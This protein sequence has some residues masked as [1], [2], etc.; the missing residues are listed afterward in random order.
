MITIY[1]SPSCSS[2]RK[3]KH[4]LD[5]YGLE[6]V[7]KNLFITPLSTQE[8]KDILEKTENGTE[9]IISTRSKVITENNIDIDAMSMNE[10]I[11]FIKENPSALKRPI[12]IEGNKLQI[13]YNAEE[14]RMFIPRE[15]RN[16]TRIIDEQK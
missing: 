6:Y 4:W 9:D 16:Q 10:L 2:C 3:A 14:I 12:I 7:E 5:S 13:G 15:Y 1:I 8:I 11:E